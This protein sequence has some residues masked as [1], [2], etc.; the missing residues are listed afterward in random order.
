MKACCFLGIG[1][2][3]VHTSKKKKLKN[4][5]GLSYLSQVLYSDIHKY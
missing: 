5:M 4:L 2:N 3:K 1:S